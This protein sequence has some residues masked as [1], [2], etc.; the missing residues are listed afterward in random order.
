M[1]TFIR[2]IKWFG[3][4]MLSV[5]SV[6]AGM[7][8]WPLTEIDWVAEKGPFVLDGVHIV[9]VHTGVLLE[10]M[11]VSIREGRI[12]A[13]GK[14]GE[15]TIPQG[16]NVLDT[17]GKYVIPGLW[18]MHTH[19]YKLSPQIHHPLYIAYGVTGVRDM[20]GCL[21][22]D[23]SYWACSHDREQWNKDLASARRVTPRYVLQSSFQT[24]GGNEVPEG[25][26][27]FFR[28]ESRED[29]RKLAQFYAQAGTDFI[30]VYSELS[31]SQYR[32]LAS[33]SAQFGLSIAGHKPLKV[34]LHDA[35]SSGQTSIEHG[36]LFLFECFAGIEGFRQHANP[37][38]HYNVELMWRMVEE[39][40]EAKCGQLM[41]DMAASDTWW[42]PT[43]TTLRMGAYAD[44]PGFRQDARLNQIPALIKHMI[45]F[46]DANY[47]ASNNLAAN[48]QFVRKAFF[49]EALSQVGRAHDKGVK[50]LAGTDVSDTY[51]FTGSGLHEELAML[52]DAGLSP[53]EAIRSATIHAAQFSGQ[54]GDFGSID[55]GKVA[56]MVL[57]NTNPLKDIRHSQDI[58]AV[59]HNGFF[60]N[61]AA[62]DSL[63]DFVEQQAGSV[64]VNL[65]F[66]FDVLAS[67]LMRTQFAD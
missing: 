25:F 30:K 6:L 26:S 20:S 49:A 29:A 28:L 2:C 17:R 50:I 60:Y 10:D 16:A 51:V 8:A 12:D 59:I 19:S 57:L 15:L 54:S 14:Q 11:T 66:L 22:K 65:R 9:D 55:A 40:D 4:L 24:N 32:M 45:W 37:I 13:I 35:I 42:V 1:S 53:M 39:Q 36:R 21:E 31:A 44:E 64:R 47:A 3:V 61:R 27:S 7:V 23:D 52:V 41:E 46:P 48:G 38:R 5:I 63:V 56:D 58:F 62:L 67:P 43:L 18:D 33:A 34:S